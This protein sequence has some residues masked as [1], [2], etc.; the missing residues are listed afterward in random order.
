[1]SELPLFVIFIYVFIC[2]RLI[3]D[4][5]EYRIHIAAAMT[6]GV[7]SAVV[8]NPI[9]VVKTRLMVLFYSFLFLTL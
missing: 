7:A 5:P 3:S 4:R 8:T 2:K 1:M 9:W 6:A